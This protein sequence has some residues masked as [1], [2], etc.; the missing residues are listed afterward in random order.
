MTHA[1]IK[2][3]AQNRKHYHTDPEC[4]DLLKIK[5]ETREVHKEGAEQIGLTECKRCSDS[6][7]KNTCDWSYYQAARDAAND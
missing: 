3:S 6:V 7:I 4:P 1:Y 2:V 5:T